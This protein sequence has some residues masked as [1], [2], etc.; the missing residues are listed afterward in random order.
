MAIP[1]EARTEHRSQDLPLEPVAATG[2]H[3][4]DQDGD[5]TPGE[6]HLTGSTP[7]L[8]ANRNQAT[9]GDP[10]ADGSGA[11]LEVLDD[12]RDGDQDVIAR[13]HGGYSLRSRETSQPFLLFNVA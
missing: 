6:P 10:G 5:L 2:A 4:V 11:H 3:T 8:T 1:A 7:T 9:G 12:L 13:T